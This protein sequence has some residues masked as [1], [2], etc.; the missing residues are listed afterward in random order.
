MVDKVT[1]NGSLQAAMGAL[2]GLIG[3]LLDNLP[4]IIDVGLQLARRAATDALDAA[5]L[6]PEDVDCI[7]AVSVTGIAVPSLEARLVPLVGF[8]PDVKRLPLF[9]LG[10]VAG[11]AGVAR[12][13][14]YLIGHPDE[15]VLLLSTELCSLTL[16]H[17]DDSMANLV[18]SALFGDGAAAVVMLGE[19]RARRTGLPGP[20]VLRTV[21]RLYPGTEDAM[22]WDVGGGG[23]RVVL[24]P[25]VPGIVREHLREDTE[26]FLADDGLTVNDIGRLVAHPGGPKVLTAM[27]ESLGRPDSDFAV[28]WDRLAQTGNLSS[29]SVLHVLQGTMEQRP[30]PGETGLLVAM[31]PGFCSE[32]IL[33]SW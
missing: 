10:C 28:T 33:L 21:S 24:S 8:R 25:E 20:R 13:H 30:E 26:K 6:H 29:A 14:D 17:D 23:F 3:V 31:G 18:A 15:V 16:Q 27:A 32:L 7:I 11:A 19:Q 2:V 1:A 22:G 9:G 12:A 4:G 5:R